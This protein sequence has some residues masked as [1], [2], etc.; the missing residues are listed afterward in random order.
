MNDRW[1]L[2]GFQTAV[3]QTAKATAFATTT[4]RGKRLRD[5]MYP[6]PEKVNEL[7]TSYSIKWVANACFTSPQGSRLLNYTYKRT[8]ITRLPFISPAAAV[9]AAA[10][11][12][13]VGAAPVGAASRTAR[14]LPAGL[15]ALV[16]A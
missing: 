9:A 16:A 12:A 11:G 15:A 1:R 14:A 4:E 2:I 5:T 7:T 3:S 10:G 13:F 6:Y 8:L